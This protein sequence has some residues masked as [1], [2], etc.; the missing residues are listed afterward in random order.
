M[1]KLLARIA[2]PLVPAFLLLV[3]SAGIPAGPALIAL[4]LSVD[5]PDTGTVPAGGSPACT[6]PAPAH[7][8]AL[9]H[10][11]TPAD[12]AAAYGI[13]RFRAAHP[14]DSAALGAGQTIVLVD[15]YGS[16]TAANDINFFHNTF[17]PGLPA[18]NFDE[19]YPNGQL[20]FDNTATGNGLSG[21]SGAVGW[22]VEATLD[23]EWAYAMAPLAHI[24]MLATNPAETLGVTGLPNMFKAIRDAIDTYPA[25]T[26][27][28]QSF[29]LA[30]QTFGGAAPVQTAGFD[31]TYKHGIS[32]GDTFVASS[33]DQGSGGN[34]KTHKLTGVYPF[35]VVGYPASSPYNLA[36]GGTQLM[37]NWLWAPTS[38]DFLIPGSNALNPAFFASTPATG[39]AAEP[40]WQEAWLGPGNNTSAG[41]K[42]VVYSSP[43]WQATQASITGGMRG[44]PDLSWNAAVNGG[45]LIYITAFPNGSPSGSPTGIRPGWHIEGGTSAASPQIAGLVAVVNAMRAEKGKTPIG[46]PH[47][48]VYAL[49]NSQNAS[50]YYRD[51]TPGH[52]GTVGYPLVDN[53]W[54][55]NTP[56]VPGFPVTAGWD[57]TT[58]FGSPLADSWIPALVSS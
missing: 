33:G 24:V 45:V 41:G 22:S 2:T 37:Y 17:Y 26:V 48:A 52:F 21:P 8:Y 39:V 25:G 20:T 42:S 49:G 27:F 31:E 6:T 46:D 36:V 7:T 14:G 13:D 56:S 47:A 38:T 4:P 18:P 16:P 3:S 34:D 30:E 12:I 50:T 44:L 58:G 19:V 55:T 53:R 32:K 40:V 54:I 23:M 29:G 43:S 28:S 10:C 11:Y 9:E 5:A 57:M 51:V 15:S 1:S 35:Q